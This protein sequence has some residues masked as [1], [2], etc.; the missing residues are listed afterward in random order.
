MNWTLVTLAAFG[1]LGVLVWLQRRRTAERVWPAW[2]AVLGKGELERYEDL[3]QSLSDA[4]GMLTDTL[5]LAR[6]RAEQCDTAD[7]LRVLGCAA[8]HVERHVPDVAV[9]LAMWRTMAHAVQALRPLPQLGVL[10]FQT[11]RLRGAATLDRVV[12]VTLDTSHRFALRVWVL[13]R[14]L[15]VVRRGFTGAAHSGQEPPRAATTANAD[16]NG[17]LRRLEALNEDLASLHSASLDTYKTLLSSMGQP[18]Q[19]DRARE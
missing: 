12:R 15:G 2:H 3:Q 7:A 6:Q 11:W 10:Q 19:T 14:G 16:L 4:H 5:A 18:G 1:L 13:I 8:G 9:R 17:R